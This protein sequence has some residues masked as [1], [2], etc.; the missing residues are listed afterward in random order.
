[1]SE[2]PLERLVIGGQRVESASGGYFDDVNPAT[3]LAI[4]RIA[5]G[6]SADVDLAVAAARTA[7]RTWRETSADDRKAAL[8]RLAGLVDD[9]KSRIARME[10][11]DA[12][13]PL[14]AVQSFDVPEGAARFSHYAPLTHRIDK[15]ELAQGRK[16]SAYVLRE[17]FGVVGVVVPSNYPFLLAS[18][19]IAPAIAAGNAVVVKPSP[20]APRSALCLADL[21]KEAG[22]PNGLI[23]VIPGFADVGQAIVAHPDVCL[24]AF[25]G[26]TQAGRAVMITAAAYLKPVILE[27]GGKSAMIIDSPGELTGAERG[28]YLDDAAKRAF[29]AAF[30]NT[31]QLC[32]A[33]SRLLIHQDVHDEV[34]G[35]LVAYVEAKKSVM[36][37]PSHP[38]TEF[39]PLVSETYLSRALE[40]VHRAVADGA[41]LRVGGKRPDGE[42]FARGNF[43]ELTI[44]ENVADDSSLAQEEV[45]GPVLAVL[46]PYN[47]IDEA[48][49]RANNTQFGLVG[50]VQTPNPEVA[51]YVARRLN[52]GTVWA[53]ATVNR[54]DPGIPFAGRGASGFGV[55]LGEDGFYAFTQPKSVWGMGDKAP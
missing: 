30:L 6:S 43:M 33:N 24:V 2:L 44:L 21:A 38:T 42:A 9:R 16:G 25:T 1:M 47:T 34:L 36:G 48:I 7:Q 46:R 41:R 4:A 23:N 50:S 14:K 12:G 17:P 49:A 27:L 3:G 10:T 35:R 55:S 13:K 28:K 8:L 37:D 19:F 31:G 5:H 20:E 51:G 39:G 11:A 53:G 18:N 29:Y 40:Y 26:G 32:T 22:L 15:A 45:F 54:F 52:V